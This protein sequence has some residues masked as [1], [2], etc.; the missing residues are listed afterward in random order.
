M[1][2]ESSL[3]ALPA[4]YS[5][6]KLKTALTTITITIATL[7]WGA[8]ATRASAAAAHSMSAKK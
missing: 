5:W 1:S 6:A 4:R 7:S 3:T 2:A 8:P